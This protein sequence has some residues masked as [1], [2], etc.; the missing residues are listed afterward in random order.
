MNK[1]VT[2]YDLC[3]ATWSNIDTEII[4]FFEDYPDP[5]MTH[6]FWAEV[7]VSFEHVFPMFIHSINLSTGK[8]VYAKPLEPS[9]VLELEN[10][11]CDSPITLSYFFEQLYVGG[12]GIENGAVK[13]YTKYF[14]KAKLKIY[15]P[16]M[17]KVILEI[18]A[19][20]DHQWMKAVPNPYGIIYHCDKCDETKFS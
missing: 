3:E 12:V 16:R 15:D 13:Y 18:N 8:V 20:C 7:E 9:K 4:G 6:Q 11:K 19:E 10:K 5:I 2:I 17:V 1:K 14:K